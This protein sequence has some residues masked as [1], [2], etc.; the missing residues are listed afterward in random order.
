MRAYPNSVP[1]V[2]GR[3][4]ALLRICPASVSDFL[5]TFALW[6]NQTCTDNQVTNI[7]TNDATFTASRV[8][9][10]TLTQWNRTPRMTWLRLAS[11]MKLVQRRQNLSTR[12]WYEICGKYDADANLNATAVSR[13]VI[14]SSSLSAVSA[15]GTK[16]VVIERKAITE[17]GA[18]TLS[19]IKFGFRQTQARRCTAGKRLLAVAPTV[20]ISGLTEGERTH[21]SSK[22]KL[23]VSTPSCGGSRSLSVSMNSTGTGPSLAQFMLTVMVRS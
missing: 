11:T 13:M 9:S 19:R 23:T 16:N 10:W 14:E 2:H 18:A 5:A 7:A 20:V 17:V 8:A 21:M 3:S 22:A 4:V 6:K 1:E 15:G 12:V